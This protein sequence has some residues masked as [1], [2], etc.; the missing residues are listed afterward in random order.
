M[1][2]SRTIGHGN[3]AFLADL[4]TNVSDATMRERFK[5]GSYN[6]LH[7]PSVKAWRKLAGRS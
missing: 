4:A 1:S 6:P 2:A 5:A 7:T 3:A